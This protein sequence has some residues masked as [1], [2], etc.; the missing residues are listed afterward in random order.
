MFAQ[1]FGK[2][3]EVVLAKI[4]IKSVLIAQSKAADKICKIITLNIVFKSVAGKIG[5]KIFPRYVQTQK[6]GIILKG[7]KNN[8]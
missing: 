1:V 5:M 2:I 6:L 4:G 8:K 7:L 3:A